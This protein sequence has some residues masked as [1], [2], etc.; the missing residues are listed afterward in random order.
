M[1]ITYIGEVNEFTVLILVPD[2]AYTVTT[3]L[4][5]VELAKCSMEEESVK[6]AGNSFLNLSTF[7]GL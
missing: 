2:S 7:Q 4:A 3:L 1:K 6:Q 5:I